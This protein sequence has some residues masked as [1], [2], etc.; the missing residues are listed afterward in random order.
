MYG[1]YVGTYVHTSY[2]YE[3]IFKQKAWRH[4]KGLSF[5][6]STGINTYTSA[7]IHVHTENIVADIENFIDLNA[8]I[9]T[10]GVYNL[11]VSNSIQLNV[12]LLKHLFVVRKENA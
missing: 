3:N 11:C 8:A 2:I 1:I 6:R 9:N 5:H 10:N 12:I 4:V 7:Y